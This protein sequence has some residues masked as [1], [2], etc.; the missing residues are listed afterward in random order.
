MLLRERKVILTLIVF[1][2]SGVGVGV[3]VGAEICPEPELSKMGSSGNSG[4]MPSNN[5]TFMNVG[6]GEADSKVPLWNLG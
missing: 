5:F 6:A 1:W 2:F 3:G 4:K